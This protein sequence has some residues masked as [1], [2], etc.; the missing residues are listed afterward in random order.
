M[1]DEFLSAWFAWQ[2]WCRMK[3]NGNQEQR[4]ER[5]EEEIEPDSEE[6]NI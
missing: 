3:K 6:E 2:K 4:E 5:L 1:I